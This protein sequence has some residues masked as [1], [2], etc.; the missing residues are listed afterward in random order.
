MLMAQTRHWHTWVAGIVQASTVGNDVPLNLRLRGDTFWVANS[1]GKLSLQ[2]QPPVAKSAKRFIVYGTV[3]LNSCRNSSTKFIQD[4]N[5]YSIYCMRPSTK[6]KM[7]ENVSMLNLIV[8]FQNSLQSCSW[9]SQ[10]A[11]EGPQHHVDVQ[12]PDRLQF[13]ATT[14][15]LE[16][17][18]VHRRPQSVHI[19]QSYA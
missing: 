5:I 1:S 14:S 12:A 7:M 17:H 3:L 16:I 8:R 2:R 11:D 18:V 10:E 6:W 15:T 19:S 4:D 13:L 9:P